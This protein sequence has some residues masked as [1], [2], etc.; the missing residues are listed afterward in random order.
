VGWGTDMRAWIVAF[1]TS[2]TAQTVTVSLFPERGGA[3]GPQTW[4]ATL[5]A[6]TR[7]SWAVHERITGAFASSVTF[8]S[9][10]GVAALAQWDAAMSR[11]SHVPGAW[12]CVGMP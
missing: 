7:Q 9:G 2:D 10:L 12:R 6:R 11:V 1:N 4:T 5:P 3:S 8:A